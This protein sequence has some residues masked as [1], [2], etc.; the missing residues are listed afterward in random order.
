[1][2]ADIGRNVHIA[3]FRIEL[4]QFQRGEYR[5]FGAAGAEPG[6]TFRDR[7]AEQFGGQFLV[8]GHG[9]CDQRDGTEVDT[10]R[11]RAF[12]E[13]CESVHHHFGLVFTRHGEDVLADDRCVQIGL[14]QH[15]VQ[16]LFQISGEAFFDN[17]DRPLASAESGDFFGHHRIGHVHA[18][19]R[20][21]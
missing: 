8:V 9:F 11:H 12:D 13:F 5:A 14:A 3:D 21:A 2:T 19:D 1:M 17:A 7:R 4:C 6:R 15:R 16:R 10:F 20:D 18:I